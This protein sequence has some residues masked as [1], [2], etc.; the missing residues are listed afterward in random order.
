MGNNKPIGNLKIALLILLFCSNNHFIYANLSKETNQPERI[1][2]NITENPSTSQA[3]TW[4][5]NLIGSKQQA[6][7]TP[8]T[9]LTKLSKNSR[10][11][12]AKTEKINLDG[13]KIIY[14]HSLIFDSLEPDTL[15]AYRVGEKKN[16][17]EWNQF[18]T[19]SKK[20]KPF[21]FI[22]L[23]DP[24]TN[25]KSMCS[26]IFREAYKKAADAKFWLITGDLVNN[27]G[28]DKLWAEFYYALGWIPRTLPIILLPGNHCYPIESRNG[29]K[30]SEIYPLWRP[31][32]TLP[33]NGPEG[34]EET[35]YYYDYQ[36]VKFIILNGNEK[37][38]EQAIWLE[39]VLKKNQ[40]SWTIIAIHQTFYPTVLNRDNPHLRKHLLPII[41]KY[42]VDLVLE[43]HDHSYGR[44]AKLR[45]GIKVSDNEKG[46]VYITSVCGTKSYPINEENKKTMEK[47]GTG[48]QLFQ[49]ITILKN[50]LNYE[51][52]DATGKPYDS[53]TLDK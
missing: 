38:K 46:T 49:V 29:E 2:L 14:Q 44:T 7:I 50:S 23:G 47:I 48:R 8:S 28:N 24:Q 20:F 12:F 16:W 40:Q 25:V 42:S 32:F 30:V 26:R 53:F 35:A 52:F 13:N 36:G 6:Q 22:Y 39:D 11:V 18:R 33:E 5:T 45:N 1:I 27:G 37:I 21:K 9:G 3:I 4:R 17:S 10:T 51:S 31:Q 19:A 43:G 41:D 15:Y 34:L